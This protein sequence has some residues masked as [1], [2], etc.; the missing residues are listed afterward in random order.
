MAYHHWVPFH[1]ILHEWCLGEAVRYTIISCQMCDAKVYVT[2]LLGKAKSHG[3]VCS[4]IVSPSVLLR[5]RLSGPMSWDLCGSQSSSFLCS[6]QRWTCDSN[7]SWQV[8]GPSWCSVTSSSSVF[9]VFFDDWGPNAIPYSVVM[10][11]E[12]CTHDPASSG[13]TC[14]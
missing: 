10:M 4:E 11:L 9:L 8:A 2:L 14:R 7:G 13:I 6:Q 12:V 1:H 3:H 5:P